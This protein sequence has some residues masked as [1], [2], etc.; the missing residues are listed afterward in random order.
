M[1]EI[2]A[3]RL[4]INALK[5]INAS[6][7]GQYYGQFWLKNSWERR[8]NAIEQIWNQRKWMKSSTCKWI[9]TCDE[10]MS[11]LFIPMN[12]TLIT[13]KGNLWSNEKHQDEVLT[14]PFFFFCADDERAATRRSSSRRW[15]RTWRWRR[16]S[17]PKRT[18]TLPR[19]AATTRRR[20]CTAATWTIDPKTNWPWFLKRRKWQQR[21]ALTKYQPSPR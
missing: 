12:Q 21:N 9:F 6:W 5:H 11:V 14:C 2:T 15:T 4:S 16:R 10:W 7:T 17:W 19:A 8:T 1:Q 13:T 18:R 20:R 3:F